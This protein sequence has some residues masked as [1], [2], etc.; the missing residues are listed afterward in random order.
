MP[1]GVQ[2]GSEIDLTDRTYDGQ[3]DEGYLSG[4]IGQLVD[5]QKGPDNFRLDSNG[6]GKGKNSVTCVKQIFIFLS[7]QEYVNKVP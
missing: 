4:G 5:G 7:S 2:R 3:E 1:Q 6:N